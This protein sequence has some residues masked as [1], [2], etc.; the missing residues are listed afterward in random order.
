MVA[1][2]TMSDVSKSNQ[3]APVISP[4][5]MMVREAVLTLASPG[6][7]EGVIRQAL[8]LAGTHQVPA[9]GSRLREAARHVF[10]GDTNLP[11]VVRLAV[12]RAFDYFDELKLSGSPL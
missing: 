5:A 8:D 1:F 11:D 4:A 2:V 12:G 10:I 3:P 9:G 7:C 6:V